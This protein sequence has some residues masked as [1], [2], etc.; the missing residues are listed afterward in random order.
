MREA[1][2]V[3]ARSIAFPAISAGIF[4]WVV[5]EVAEVGV[6]TVHDSSLLPHLSLV[7]F[8]LFGPEALAAF[9]T[10]LSRLGD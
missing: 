5:D 1:V 8:V 7:R 6:R 3:G 2:R 4:G 10:Q 9:E